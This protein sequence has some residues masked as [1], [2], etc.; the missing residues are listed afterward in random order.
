MQVICP[1]CQIFLV[2]LIPDRVKRCSDGQLVGWLRH[3][4]DLGCHAKQAIVV[5]VH[6]V[7]IDPDDRLGKRL[8][9]RQV[10]ELCAAE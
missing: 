5:I 7:E 3:P 4:R 6:P 2:S 8:K 1:T 10:E 9:R